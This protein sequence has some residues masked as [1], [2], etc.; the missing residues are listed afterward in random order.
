MLSFQNKTEKNLTW[1]CDVTAATFIQD[2]ICD[3]L[4][5]AAIFRVG[6]NSWQRV[7][8]AVRFKGCWESGV[9][10]KI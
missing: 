7:L 9:L 1:P 8:S 5:N 6:T 10:E 2:H 4:I 3:A